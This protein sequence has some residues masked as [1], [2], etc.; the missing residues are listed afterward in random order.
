M[1]IELA[2]SLDLFIL[3]VLYK[4]MKRF[5]IQILNNLFQ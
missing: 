5:Y 2:S 3:N 4:E 1:F